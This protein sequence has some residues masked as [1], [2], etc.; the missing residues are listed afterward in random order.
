MKKVS[1]CLQGAS[2]TRYQKNYLNSRIRRLFRKHRKTLEKSYVP[3]KIDQCQLERI[4]RG[5]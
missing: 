3:C 2:Q 5:G 4:E 1:S